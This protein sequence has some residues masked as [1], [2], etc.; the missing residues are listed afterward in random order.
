MKFKNKK[1]CFAS[2]SHKRLYTFECNE[3]IEPRLRDYI[4]LSRIV[5]L[6]NNFWE[7]NFHIQ[8]QCIVWPNSNFMKNQL[9]AP[10][11]LSTSLFQKQFPLWEC[12]SYYNLEE[13]CWFPLL[14]QHRY[15]LI[16]R[17]LK[18]KIFIEHVECTKLANLQR[19]VQL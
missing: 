7:W 2:S 4:P 8:M 3:N 6:T 18:F 10:F 13:E 17:H 19:L 11:L 12:K 16:F 9:N 5:F 1:K 14:I 15:T